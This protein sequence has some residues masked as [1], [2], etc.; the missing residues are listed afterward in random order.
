M[1]A[2]LQRISPFIGVPYDHFSLFGFNCWSFV[3]AVY[4]ELLSEDLVEFK[5]TTG[6]AREIASV[7]S[8]ALASGEHKFRQVEEAQDLDLIL[9][10]GRKLHHVGIMIEGRVA[11]CSKGAGGVAIQDLKTLE[12]TFQEWSL[13][14]K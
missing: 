12:N 11:H 8:A 5:L 1:N 10:K 3:A 4:H 6:S 7:F 14:R 9:F 13:W 2:N